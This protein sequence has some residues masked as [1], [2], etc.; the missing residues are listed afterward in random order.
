MKRILFNIY[1]WPCFFALTVI[2]VTLT[3]T[4]ARIMMLCRYQNVDRFVRAAIMVYGLV[5]V[6]VIA[7]VV[8]IRLNDRSGGFQTPVIFVSN[9][10][11]SIEPYLFALLKV[12]LAFITTW[13]F[14]IPV[15]SI[16]MRWA[17]YI[18]ADHGWDRVLEAGRKL[19]ER[20]CS[21]VVWP[22]GHRSR[23]GRL[24]RF[25]NGAFYLACELDCVVVPVCMKG[26]AQAMP[27]GSR[28]LNPSPVEMVLLP[29][30]KPDTTMDR[31]HCIHELKHRVRR[32][33]E[34]ELERG[35]SS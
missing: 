23:D 32:A 21:L 10:C 35:G 27:P 26:T 24:Q 7:F 19:L 30:M 11:S 12:Q 15:Y 3:W 6:R 16:F 18:N 33:I 28:L 25:K 31:I 29:A 9:H 2:G 22:E 20:G 17:G 34:A 5:I 13:P 8:P 4:A 14:R 1:F